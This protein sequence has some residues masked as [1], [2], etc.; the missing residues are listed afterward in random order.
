M[1]NFTHLFVWASLLAC[2]LSPISAN[3]ADKD[4]IITDTP[5]GQYKSYFRSSRAYFQFW[6]YIFYEDVADRVGD[7]RVD[8]DTYYFLN[9]ITKMRTDS[10]Y[11]GTRKGDTIYVDTPQPFVLQREWHGLLSL[12]PCAQCQ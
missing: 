7:V 4:N 2:M 9:P 5:S 11:K 1:R 10:W 8:G 12:P 6:S 3:A